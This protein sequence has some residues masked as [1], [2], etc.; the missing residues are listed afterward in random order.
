ML[1]KLAGP[2]MIEHRGAAPRHL[3]SAQAQVAFAR[4]TLERASGTGRDQLA[5][6]VWP[7]GLPETWASALRSVVSRVRAFV[8]SAESPDG[9]PVVA[10][11]GRYLLRLPQEASVDL[12]RAEEQ[13]QEAGRA[14]T[15][16]AYADAQRF[17]SAGVTC[18][19][20]P[21]LPE[22]EGEWVNAVRERVHSLLVSGLETASLAAAAIGDGREAL[23]YAD[24]AVRQAPLRESAHRCRMTAHAAAGNRAEA[25]RA[26]HRLRRMLAEELGVDPAPETQAAYIDLLGG[27]AT[28]APADPSGRTVVAPLFVGRA[29]ELARLAAAWAD[30]AQGEGRMVLIT[31]PPGVG[32]TRLAAT[33]AQRVGLDGGT[34]LYGHCDHGTI[35][36]Y[37]PFLEAVSG[38]VEAMP[39]DAMPQLRT[40]TRTVLNAAAD[41]DEPAPAAAAGRGELLGALSDVLL[42]VA[43]EQPVLLVLDGIET[44]DRDSLVLLRRLLRH[45]SEAGL[46]IV[47]TASSPGCDAANLAQAVV[48]ADRDGALDRIALSGLRE[49]ELLGLLRATATATSAA[50]PTPHQLLSDTDGNPYLVLQL[51][52]WYQDGLAGGPALP[53]AILEYATLR[54]AA[55]GDGPRRLLRAAAL[56][57]RTFE[58]DL[59]AEAAELDHA[60]ALDMLDVLMANQ[61]VT[62]VHDAGR[63]QRAQHRY[64]ITQDVLRRAV[65][66]R[67]SQSRRILLHGRIADAIEQH[68]PS[69]LARYSEALAHHRAAGAAAQGDARAVRWCRHAAER[70]A[71][72]GALPEAV[73]LHRQA[74]E[75]V[76]ADDHDLRAEALINLG[77]A[78]LAAADQACAQNLFDG[79]I[80][81]LHRGRIEIA[82]RAVLGLAD[83]VM[84]SSRLRSE[85]VAL[86]D[87]LIRG[88]VDGHYRDT[89]DD[90][91]LVRLL[92]RQVRLG[93]LE[94][95]G[96]VPRAALSTLTWR[97]GELG[98]DQRKL[99]GELAADM[100]DVARATGDQH[101]RLIAAHHC[102]TV[103]EM[104]GDLAAREVALQELAAAVKDSDGLLPAGEMLLLE[105]AVATAVT[106]GRFVDALAVHRLVRRLP[107][108]GIN[109]QPGTV[110]GRQMLIARWLRAGRW[111]HA[112][113]EPTGA[114]EAIEQSLSSLVGGERGMPHLTIRAVATGAVALPGGDDWLH[115]A[116]LLALGGVELNDP[117]T[118]EALQDR[119]MPYAGV[120]CGVG[121]RSYVGPVALHLGRLAT[122]TGDWVAAE[123]HLTSALS[124]LA[125]RGARPW[126]ALA[127]TSLAEA[128]QARGRPG[129]RRYSEALLNEAWQT[130]STVGLRPDVR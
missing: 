34:V 60:Q 63:H 59:V 100:L 8:T 93:A 45:R 14:F 128:L 13:V 84:V 130:L 39:Q 15:A 70:A 58:L 20:Y 124:V 43:R 2:V 117:Q 118:A 55:L 121:Y 105:H 9:P 1:I 77:L 74:L 64:R 122:V 40:S 71:G 99:R 11:G 41:C 44:A 22:H 98:P 92:A 76:P 125:E 56:S 91:S 46:L 101:A 113:N 116:G 95:A 30:T 82:A 79:A 27:A 65:D 33:A 107:V 69:E 102:A 54:L 24:D 110:A 4:L 62:E 66:E 83:A 7:E 38:F 51:L 18:L 68:R 61:L 21:F 103:A 42:G 114:V 126:M 26:Y 85:A 129:D 106:E 10:Q 5:D 80:R 104:A 112:G 31:G 123:R 108:D 87:S 28:V 120:T 67:A 72:W 75:H 96:D 53:P 23:R 19:R 94:P 57:G 16:G 89:V 48:E 88:A 29:A 47:A 50:M 35:Q 32:K 78:Q 127:Q 109:P 81:A 119:L 73:Q 97:L 115:A 12:E 49:P 36:P 90:V 25:L 37:Q 6:T 17:A 52:R 86:L 3:T 111:P